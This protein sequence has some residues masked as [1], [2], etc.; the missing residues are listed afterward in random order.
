MKKTVALLVGLSMALALL[1]TGAGAQEGD[2]SPTI[3][4]E[5]SDTTVK[6][7]PA[8]TVRVEQDEGEEELRDV[9]LKIPKG[10]GLAADDD[11]PG[12]TTLGEGDIDIQ[13]GFVCRPG[14]E[15]GIPVGTMVNVPTELSEVDRDQNAKDAGIHA[16]W[17]LDIG[18]PIT[19]TTIMLN[20][21]GSVKKGWTIQGDVPPNDNTCP[22]FS[23]ELT[24]NE[25]ADGVPIYTNPKKP[26]KYVF[27][28]IFTTSDSPTV[29]NLKQ[30]IQ[31]TK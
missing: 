3:E 17:R 4:F 15:G 21:T 22:P 6:A 7:N 10:F 25:E 31:I 23:F 1:A 9:T 11:I 20:V 28:A 8:V 14:A 24:V 12:G 27:K 2:F 30:A 18:S 26:G 13:V 19:L 29:V 16:V 5:L